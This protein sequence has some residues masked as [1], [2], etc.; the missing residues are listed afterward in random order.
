MPYG[1]LTQLGDIPLGAQFVLPETWSAPG[2]WTLA[3]KPPPGMV[4]RREDSLCVITNGG[5]VRQVSPLIEIQYDGGGAS[6]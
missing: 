1:R 2:I 3:K 6:Q 5:Q 4:T